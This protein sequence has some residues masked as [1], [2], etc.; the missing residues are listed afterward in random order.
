MRHIGVFLAAATLCGQVKLT[1][2]PDRISVEIDGRP[3]TALFFGSENNKPYLH[4][5][6]AASGTIVTRLYPMEKG[7]GETTDHPH[8]RG[9]W[10]SHGDVNGYDFWG[11]EPSQKTAKTGRIVLLKV[12]DVNSGEKSGTLHAVFGWQ[13]PKGQTIL[14]EHRGMVF[15]ADP[16]ERIIDL[17]IRLEPLVKVTFGDTKEGTFAIR[18][19]TGLQEDK[20]NGTMVSSE[21]GRGEKEC[22]GKRAEWM[23]Y[24][25]ELNG[26]KLGV[27]IFDHPGNPRHPAYWHARAYGLF[28]VNIFGVRDFL[29]DKSADGSLTIEPGHD[30][31]F[32]YRVIIHPGD[33]QAAKLAARYKDYK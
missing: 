25:G 7:A 22:W 30:L 29:N 12:E 19:A 15:H 24:F 21:G 10:F 26:E 9:L 4:P 1:Q 23:D 16:A 31:R 8:H 14:A 11:N 20:H 2:A 27:A 33:N 17:D 6:R 3:S 32:R 13:D 18:L 5:L 28:A